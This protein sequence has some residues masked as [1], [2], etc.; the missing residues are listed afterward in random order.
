MC[1]YN[2]RYAPRPV[3]SAALLVVM[4]V[5]A[6]GCSR[7]DATTISPAAEAT[8]Q[9][10]TAENQ[11]L[12]DEVA[13]LRAAAP[14]AGGDLVGSM[15]QAASGNVGPEEAAVDESVSED[16]AVSPLDTEADAAAAPT[17][18][19]EPLPTPTPLPT[20][21]PQPMTGEP[22]AGLYAPAARFA[23]LW[24]ADEDHQQA[25]GWGREAEETS[26]SV[27]VQPFEHGLM[28]WR[29]DSSQIYALWEGADGQHWRVVDDTFAEGEPELDPAL[30]PPG[31]LLQPERGFGKVWRQDPGLRDALGWALVRESPD[32]AFIQ[33]FER[34]LMFNLG[35][36]V[37]LIGQTPGGETIWFS[38]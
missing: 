19:L 2:D 11:R 22:P 23:N 38:E 15:A 8:I 32:Q 31:G 6:G 20:F 28:I 1:R 36:R 33:P 29:E 17:A 21:V 9:A 12:A 7:S 10:L 3:L 24:R 25:V 14:E 30:S 26:V 16:G 37:Y 18:T 34:G 35:A 27:V 5:F 4:T 13:A